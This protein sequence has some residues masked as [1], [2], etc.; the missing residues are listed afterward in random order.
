MQ[1]DVQQ[2]WAHV[3]T[4]RTPHVNATAR[5]NNTQHDAGKAT[6]DHASVEITSTGNTWLPAMPRHPHDQIPRDVLQQPGRSPAWVPII[7]TYNRRT[8]TKVCIC[9]ALVDV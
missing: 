4:Q 8:L 9:S 5:S 7:V 3:Q 1:L 2:M 6:L